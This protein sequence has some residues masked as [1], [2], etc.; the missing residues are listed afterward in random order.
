MKESI[1][2]LYLSK[3]DIEKT[4]IDMKTTIRVI[5]DV[6]RAHYER[7]VKL[8][9]KIQL[10]VEKCPDSYFMA[11]PA[12]LEYLDVCGMKWISGYA[13]NPKKHNL[14]ASIGTIVLNDAKTGVPI[15]VM[16][17]TLITALRTGAVT[18]VGS[19]YLAKD[20]SQSIGIVGAS[21][22]G[23]YQL[24]A[25]NEVFE[26]KEVKIFD[27]NNDATRRYLEEMTR[28]LKLNIKAVGSYEELVKGTDIVV[29]AARTTE[30]YFH[31]KLI[32]PNS[33]VFISAVTGGFFPNVLK[34]IDKIVCDEWE[35]WK[36]LEWLSDFYKQGLINEK[37]IYAELGE[38][39]AGK[40]PGRETNE[41]VILFAHMGMATEDV[42]LAYKIYQLARNKGLG[43]KLELLD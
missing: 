32:I 23:R 16:D 18:A 6:F 39:V 28:K 27:T 37:D 4:D 15:A 38:I 36:H 40:K 17:G 43:R 20:G 30:P 31:G 13:H 42:A 11:M 26:I 10:Y 29:T 22:Q 12:Y 35:H 33:G 14:P 24:I 25:L 5:E 34:K 21:V 41:E 7:K 1:E 9:T 3:K 2:F 8:P 19:R